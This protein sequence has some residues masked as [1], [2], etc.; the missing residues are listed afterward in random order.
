MDRIGKLKKNLEGTLFIDDPIDLF[1]LTGL[2]LS[3][4]RLVVTKENAS[5]FVDGRYIAIAKEKAPCEVHLLSD[6]KKHVPSGPI[7][8]DSDFLSYEEFL[9]LQKSFPELI[10]TPQPL[11]ELRVIK[12]EKEIAALKKAQALTRDGYQ[13]IAGLLKEGVSEEDLA[14]EFEFFCRKHGASK[15]S[16][17]PIVAF[18]KNSAYPHHRAGKDTLKKN[19]IILLDLGCVV[20]GYAG[21]MTRCVF[22][23]EVDAQ[24]KQDYALIKG[25]QEKVIAQVVPGIAFGELNKMARAELDKAGVANLFTHGLSHGIGLDVHE[26]PRLKIKG[27]DANLVLQPGMTFTVEPGIYRP[28]LGGVRYEDVVL[29]TDKGHETL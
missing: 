18:G 9:E 28:G 5:L 12:D 17:E 25:V 16:F 8:F 21:D 1:Y 10:P 26:Y 23:G 4:G 15:L 29:V 6:L 14:L 24:L 19:Q 11:K 13:H 3:L 27:G 7:A 2:S 20:D 22:F